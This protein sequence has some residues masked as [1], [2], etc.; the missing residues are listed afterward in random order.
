MHSKNKIRIR[1]NKP[2]Y[3][4]ICIL[5]VILCVIITFFATTRGKK[6]KEKAKELSNKAKEELKKIDEEKQKEKEAVN[7]EQIKQIVTIIQTL[8]KQDNT[9]ESKS[10]N[11]T[12]LTKRIN[13]YKIELC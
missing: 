12:K 8:Q 10:Q 7:A 5:C 6:V 9:C 1:S 4:T 2:M 3:T 11:K 13:K